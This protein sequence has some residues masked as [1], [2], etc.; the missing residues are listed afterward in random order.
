MGDYTLA[1]SCTR[2]IYSAI[3]YLFQAKQMSYIDSEWLYR[4]KCNI[5]WHVL[6][7]H[8]WN[9]DCACTWVII[10]FSKYLL[11]F[12]H[13][14]TS[15]ATKLFAI[16][17]LTLKFLFLANQWATDTWQVAIQF[18][19]SFILVLIHVLKKNLNNNIFMIGAICSSQK[20]LS[21]QTGYKGIF[22]VE[23]QTVLLTF[24]CFCLK[25][26]G[27]VCGCECG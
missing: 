1:I 22:N 6:S 2:T 11:M 21:T 12:I 23:W 25:H 20:I 8:S 14:W 27:R 26:I 18:S 4:R 5:G 13:A 9:T 24:L 7:F 16:S 3:T 10:L 17:S 19:S 15:R